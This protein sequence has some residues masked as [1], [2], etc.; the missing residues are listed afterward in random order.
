MMTR[1]QAMLVVTHLSACAQKLN[2]DAYV[3]DGIQAKTV[4]EAAFILSH[5][6]N[7]LSLMER[8]TEEVKCLKVYPIGKQADVRSGFNKAM[9]IVK[10]W[11]R[12]V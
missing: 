12:E 9:G 10:R 1:D 6:G 7:P 2:P 8:L 3:I 11:M 4:V 5:A